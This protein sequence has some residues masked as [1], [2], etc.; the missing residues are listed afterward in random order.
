MN[1][2]ADCKLQL[3]QCSKC[4]GCHRLEQPDFAGD[5]KCKGVRLSEPKESIR[6]ESQRINEHI[7]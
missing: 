2:A 1:P 5:N 6:H 3:T 4:L 7:A